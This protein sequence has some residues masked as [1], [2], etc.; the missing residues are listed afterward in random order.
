MLRPCLPP[1]VDLTI[2]VYKRGK[3]GGGGH[4]CRNMTSRT[5][6]L[7]A[8]LLGLGAA[9]LIMPCYITNFAQYR[10]GIGRYVPENYQA[11]LCTHVFF[12]FGTIEPENGTAIASDPAIDLTY[13][14]IPGFYGRINNLKAKQPGL[15]TV[16]SF[17]GP[18]TPAWKFIRMATDATRRANFI[19]T[20][21]NLVKTYG[22]NG[23]DIIWQYP[24][25]ADKAHYTLLI[26]ELKAAAG[27]DLLV[28]AAVSGKKD[29]IES[30]YDVKAL[31]LLL[32]FVNVLTFDYAT[33]YD[34]NVGLSAPLETSTLYSVSGGLNLWTV[35]GFNKS[36]I[37]MGV[38][39]YNPDWILVNPNY[40]GV[41]SAGTPGVAYPFTS[42]YG[43]AAYYE[44]CSI[45]PLARR[46]WSVIERVPFMV[47]GSLW[48]SYEDAQSIAIKMKYV[49]D[50]GFGGAFVANIDLDD[51]TGLCPGHQQYP[52]ASAVKYG[53]FSAPSTSKPSEAPVTLPPAPTQKP[54]QS[55]S[56]AQPSVPTQKPASAS[57]LLPT[58][59]KPSPFVPPSPAPDFH[60]PHRGYFP[61][62][63][64][65]STFYWCGDNGIAWLMPC[66]PGS[67]WDQS[68]QSCH[69]S[70][71]GKCFQK[72]ADEKLEMPYNKFI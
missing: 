15:K 28:T 22:F 46:F 8:A 56:P 38:A 7:L 23:I 10:P 58:T 43:Y 5:L 59:Q 35:Y 30:S 62:P 25:S 66:A 41:G 32:D 63:K 12:G 29:V 69:N 34:R 26:Q 52:I 4:F 67:F 40:I 70:P 53:L 2:R 27:S 51:F 45:I 37:L 61:N 24:S 20:A 50:E 19:A 39:T 3:I 13:N 16:L 11:G 18:V 47:Y 14:N 44:M 71:D 33:P 6:L 54:T 49:R 1:S 72:A 36:Q 17:G 9:E 55:P 65:C 64:D 68:R 57:P 60:C 48:F 21:L 42:S 31:S